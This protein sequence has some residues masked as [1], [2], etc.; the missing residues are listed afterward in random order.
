MR[1]NLCCVKIKP[2]NSTRT[3]CEI[4]FM[5]YESENAILN[6][7][8]WIECYFGGIFW[9]VFL[10]AQRLRKDNHH[11]GVTEQAFVKPELLRSFSRESIT[12]QID[13]EVEITLLEGIDSTIFIL[14]CNLYIL[15]S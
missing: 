12:I 4:T 8:I 3:G 14:L 9:K 11:S 7:C 10:K 5:K 1:T 6:Q 2:G 13:M 15:L